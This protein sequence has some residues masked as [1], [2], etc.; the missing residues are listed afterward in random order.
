MGMTKPVTGRC[1]CGAVR[2]QFDEAPIM[3]RACWCRDCQY[4]AAGN[5]SVNAIFRT[6]SF[7]VSGDVSEYVSTADSGNTMRRRFCSKCGTQLFSESLSRPDIMVVRVGALDDPE[8]HRPSAFIWTG[9]APSWGFVDTGL[10][11][12]DGQPPAVI[13]K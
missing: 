13:P 8:M 12:H 7:T 11:N 10:A 9:S 3:T 6:V 5:A 2:F 4:L 1:Y